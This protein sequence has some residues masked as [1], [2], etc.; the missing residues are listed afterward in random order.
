ERRIAEFPAELRP[1][2]ETAIARL[3]DYQD[4]RYV[5][6]YLERL[7]PFAGDPE[8]ARVVA[9]HLAVWMTYEDAIRVAQLKT[10]A[11]RFERIRRE[12]G[13]LR[14][15]IVV[16]DF[17]KP[18]LDEIYG[19]L[20]HRLVAP[21]A[22]WAERR[23]PH[24]RPAFGQHVK[25]TTVLGYLRVWM[26]TLL[27]PLR[28]ISH[29]A[30]EEHA[31]M[32]Q[33]L[34]ALARCAG[35]DRALALE[36]A[37]GAQLVKGYGDVRRRM[38]AHLDRLLASVLRAA[39]CEGANGGGFEASRELAARYR[40]L[41]LQGPDGEA[42]AAA[43]AERVLTRRAAVLEDVDRQGEVCPRRGAS[44]VVP[45]GLLEAAQR[46]RLD[47]GEDLAE[48]VER[49]GLAHEVGRAQ[50][51]ALARLALGRDARDGDDRHAELAHGA[52]LEEV[53][54]AHAGQVDVEDDR[55]GALGLELA[56]RGF[57]AADD[58]RSVS[59]LE[60]E[61]SQK[62]AEARLVL[63]HQHSH[64]TASLARS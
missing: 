4:R 36:V 61:I 52:E 25:T 34:T 59:E 19:I 44:V 26:L 55:V 9:R 2:L 15:E 10:R 54:S 38:Q 46:V 24:G 39:E 20:P 6:R 41:V 47:D 3:V 43:L 5:E 29:R 11:S 22:R 17:L 64:T 62:V 60:E 23:W 14:G 63:D 1:T 42:R 35:W 30:H 56:E 16:T 57:G 27:R 40:V 18:D 32:D 21:F 8:L 49:D 7:R 13:A 33:W 37:R 45:A 28:P 58:Q 12:K 51:Q 48:A 31:R 53:D 50:A